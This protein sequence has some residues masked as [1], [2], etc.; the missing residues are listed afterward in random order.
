MRIFLLL[1]ASIILLI[2]G[3]APAV[4]VGVGATGVAYHEEDQIRE[5]IS[6]SY[7]VAYYSSLSV[8]SSKGVIT[9]H[10]KSLGKIYGKM[11]VDDTTY[12]VFI[13]VK[14]LEDNKSKVY[15]KV[16]KNLIPNLELA[17]KILDDIVDKTKE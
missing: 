9:A 17:N 7:N 13:E 5:E 2:S 10:D 4:L 14:E 8:L 1:L 12:D 3:C 6:H 11:T 15:V 16:R